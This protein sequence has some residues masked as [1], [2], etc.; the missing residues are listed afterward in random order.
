MAHQKAVYTDHYYNQR[1]K[2]SLFHKRGDK[3]YAYRHWVHYILQFVRKGGRLLEVGCGQGYFL[4]QAEKTYETYGTDLSEYATMYA[5]H[6]TVGHTPMTVADSVDLPYRSESFD[7][8]IALDM[9]EHLD[10]PGR[11]FREAYRLLKQGGVLII[12]TPNPESFGALVKK[13]NWHGARD[14]THVSLLKR[15]QWRALMLMQRFHLLAEGTDASWDSPYFQFIPVLFQKIAAMLLF[16]TTMMITKKFV[17]R[18]R[19]GEN[20]VA[21]G[22]K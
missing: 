2:S 16:D 22:R 10:D 6:E 11:F 20:Y 12:K 4:R 13:D 18:W 19:W 5:F 9:V 17:F 1:Y 14:K 7:I 3:V 8:V 15:E 21:V